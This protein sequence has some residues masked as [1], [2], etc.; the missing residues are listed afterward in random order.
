MPLVGRILTLLLN[1]KTGS[2]EKEIVSSG[3]GS[4]VTFKGEDGQ[5]YLMMITA[6]HVVFDDTTNEIKDDV[7]FYCG[8]HG[9]DASYA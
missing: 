5:S 2:G 8:Q 9:N 7:W 1:I 3:T 4:I 6:A